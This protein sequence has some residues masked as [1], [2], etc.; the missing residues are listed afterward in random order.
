MFGSPVAAAPVAVG[1]AVVLAGTAGASRKLVASLVLAGRDRRHRH[2]LLELLLGEGLL[3]GELDLAH[4]IDRDDL[5]RH[6]VPF[7]DDVGCLA[8]AVGSELGDVN[9]A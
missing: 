1:V 8:Y 3:A 6:L 7:L 5:D 4:R 9:E 2:L